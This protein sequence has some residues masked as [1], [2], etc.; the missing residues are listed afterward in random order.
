MRVGIVGSGGVARRHLEVLRH[1]EE[2]QLVGHLSSDAARAVAQAAEWGGSPYSDLVR[3]LD[4][5]QPEAVWICVTPDRHGALE[6]ALIERRIPFFVEKPLAVDLAKLSMWL[7]TAARDR[8]LSFLDHHL[9]PGN[10]LVGA[11]LEELKSAAPPAARTSGAR[12]GATAKKLREAEEAGQLSL[13]SDSAFAQ[14]MKLAVD[15][16]WLIE[17]S[18]AATVRDVKEQERLYEAVREAF[19]RKYSRLADLVTAARFGRRSCRGRSPAAARAS[20]N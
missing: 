10:A 5:A 9:R 8:P 18:A 13:A 2:V 3:L 12:K 4:D 15:N 17:E 1:I 16:M 20:S 14:S 6:L 11:R 7:A 19:V